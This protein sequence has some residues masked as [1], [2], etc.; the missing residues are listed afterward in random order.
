MITP[1]TFAVSQSY[2]CWLLQNVK[3]QQYLREI[4]TLLKFYFIS[5]IFFISLYIMVYFSSNI[6]F[7]Y[8]EGSAWIGTMEVVSNIGTKKT[9]EKC[10]KGRTKLIYYFQVFCVD[11]LLDRGK[12]VRGRDGF[13][14]F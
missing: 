8:T 14:L 11:L 9:M 5:V 3:K 2:V 10:V 12:R 4:H 13:Y 6:I 7:Y 1:T